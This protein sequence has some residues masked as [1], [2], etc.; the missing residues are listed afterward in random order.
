MSKK[1]KLRYERGEVGWASRLSEDTA[2]IENVPM[3]SSV[4]FKDVVK[5]KMDSDGMP[6]VSRVL[7]RKYPVHVGLKYPVASFKKLTKALKSAG[8]VSEGVVDG[9]MVVAGPRGCNPVEVAHEAGV[10]VWLRR[11]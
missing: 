9:T 2:S 3:S 11:L 7:R 8:C 6:I 1:F 4:N 5:F 10:A